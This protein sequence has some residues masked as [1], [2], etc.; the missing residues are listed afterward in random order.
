M[1]NEINNKNGTNVKLEPTKEK[2]R[3]KFVVK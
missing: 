1:L 3:Y 2:F